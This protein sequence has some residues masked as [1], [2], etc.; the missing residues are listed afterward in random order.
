MSDDRPTMRI[1]ASDLSAP[2]VEEYLETQAYLTRDVGEVGDQPW[3]IRV[4]YANWFYLAVTGAIGGLI[5]WLILEPFFDDKVEGVQ[6]SAILMFPVVAG[7]VGMFVGAA[8][9]L[10]CRNGL[11]TVISGAVG[12]GVGFA[13]G[14]VALFPAGMVFNIMTQIAVAFWRDPQPG[15]MP[16]GLALL[17]WMMGRAAAWGIVAIPAGIGQGIALR[18]RKVIINGLVGGVLGGMVGGLLFDPIYLILTSADGQ[19]TYSRAVGF[20]TI[21][22]FVGL[23]IG[24]VEGWTKTAWLLMRKGPLA[25]KQFIL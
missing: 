20:M 13:G 10:M 19:A 6:L 1:T 4:I 16:T 5:A 18:E 25:G 9:G 8:E 2:V 14:L 23:F 24:L 12:L 7:F 15:E 17:I 3:L 11:R 22:L 21:G